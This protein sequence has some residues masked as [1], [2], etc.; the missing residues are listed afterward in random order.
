M[1]RKD[2]SKRRKRQKQKAFVVWDD[3]SSNLL[4]MDISLAVGRG[5]EQILVLE[6]GAEGAGMDEA[7]L[8]GHLADGHLW[9]AQQQVA[10]MAQAAV[11]N[12]VGD[13]AEVAR[14]RKGRADTFLRDV[15]P[16]DGGLT[17]ES[18]VKV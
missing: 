18:R 8:L 4:T 1:K 5:G 9:V 3:E 10:A 12:E 11:A 14:L 16:A 15:E 13:A 2:K 6:V 17:V 7:A